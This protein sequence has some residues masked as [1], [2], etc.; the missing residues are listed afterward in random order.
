MYISLF[1]FPTIKKSVLLLLSLV[2]H[3]SFRRQLTFSSVGE[4]VPAAVSQ[5]KKGLLRSRVSHTLH[6]N[7]LGQIME[8]VKKLF[9]SNYFCFP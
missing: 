1:E 2:E 3:A 8:T 7:W 5:L 4:K 9:L 6:A